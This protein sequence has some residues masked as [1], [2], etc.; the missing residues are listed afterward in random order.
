MERNV[1]IKKV[2]DDNNFTG[3]SINNASTPDEKKVMWSDLV[4]GKPELEDSLSTNAKQMKAEMYTT[5]FKD[6]TDLDHPCRIPGSVYLKCL[7]DSVKTT[8][9]NRSA[10]CLPLFG[11]FDACRRAGSGGGGTRAPTTG[12]AQ[13]QRW[14]RSWCMSVPGQA[15]RSRCT[16]TSGGAQAVRRPHRAGGRCGLE[17]TAQFCDSG[18]SLS[19]DV[20][21]GWWPPRSPRLC[22]GCS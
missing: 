17:V 11:T 12:P 8:E 20:L 7:Q 5:M 6:S 1:A 19:E 2:L 14:A 16:Q 10:K 15:A 21:G 22:A 3:L 13:A 4:Q 18:R 9:K